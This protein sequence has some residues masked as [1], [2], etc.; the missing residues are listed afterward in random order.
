MLTRMSFRCHGNVTLKC[1]K[2]YRNSGFVETFFPTLCYF[3]CV[4]VYSFIIWHRLLPV[5]SRVLRRVACGWRV[6]VCVCVEGGGRVCVNEPIA[7]SPHRPVR[8]TLTINMKSLPSTSSH[9]LYTV[10][11]SM[12]NPHFLKLGTVCKKK[13]IQ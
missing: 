2:D 8:S 12:I 9:D 13:E 10:P 5:K 1:M 3:S 7:P 11:R 6:C 4:R